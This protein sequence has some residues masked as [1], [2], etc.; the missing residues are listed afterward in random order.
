MK[1]ASIVTLA[2]AFLFASPTPAFASEDEDF[3]CEHDG[4]LQCS[5]VHYQVIK[6]ARCEKSCV[7][8]QSPPPEP[9]V[10]CTFVFGGHQCSVWPRGNE[11]SYTFATSPGLDASPAGPTYSN[12]VWIG[13]PMQ[14]GGTLVVTVTSPFGLSSSSSVSL[15]CR[16]TIER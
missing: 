12:E 9:I 3:F 11:L 5:P 15:P 16:T 8:F 1:T 13:C 2:A 4:I 14:R 6:N 7:S 10:H